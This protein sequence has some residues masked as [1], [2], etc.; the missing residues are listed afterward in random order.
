MTANIFAAQTDSQTL[1]SSP[2]WVDARL[3]VLFLEPVDQRFEVL[4][5]CIRIDGRLVCEDL[6]RMSPVATCSQ[7]KHFPSKHSLISSWLLLR[8]QETVCFSFNIRP[9]DSLQLGSCFLRVVKVALV[10]WSPV[11]AQ[12]TKSLVELKLVE[13]G[14]EVSS[15]RHKCGDVVF[16]ARVK[17]KLA[18]LHWRFQTLVLFSLSENKKENNLRICDLV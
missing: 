14:D 8:I 16:G 7:L 15:V 6:E 5:H 12:S 3:A 17:V 9:D 18:S 13:V 4:E 2:S 1:L 11:S 10:Q